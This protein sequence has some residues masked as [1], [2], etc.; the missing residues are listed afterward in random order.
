MAV[1]DVQALV[2]ELVGGRREERGVLEDGEK[3][4]ELQVA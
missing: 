4:E 3:V 1:G 2:D